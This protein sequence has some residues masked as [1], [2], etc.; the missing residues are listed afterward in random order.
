MVKDQPCRILSRCDAQVPT[1]RD[2]T[3]TY[4][5]SIVEGSTLS[6]AGQ[7]FEMFR[8][9][10]FLLLSLGYPTILEQDHSLPGRTMFDACGSGHDYRPFIVAKGQPKSSLQSFQI[11]SR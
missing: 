2:P 3:T 8:H 11:L 6:L 5:N 10:C 7:I 1:P 9:L 4:Y